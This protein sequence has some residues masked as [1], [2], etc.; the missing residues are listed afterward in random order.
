MKCSVEGACQAPHLLKIL[1]A[2]AAEHS[3]EALVLKCPPLRVLVQVPH[4]EAVE[5]L[6]PLQLEQECTQSVLSQND[7]QASGRQEAGPSLTRN[8]SL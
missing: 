5:L 3:V 1:D 7:H 2:D 8:A 6:V 4:K